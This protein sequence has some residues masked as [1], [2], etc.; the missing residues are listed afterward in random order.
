LFHVTT[1]K[2]QVQNHKRVPLKAQRGE[3]A[4]N[5]Y[6]IDLGAN[7][8]A[9]NEAIDTHESNSDINPHDKNTRPKRRSTHSFLTDNGT[10]WHAATLLQIHLHSWLHHLRV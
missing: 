2:Q 5:G 1:Q 4:V 9:A 3:N 6:L 10:I 7:Q 8:L